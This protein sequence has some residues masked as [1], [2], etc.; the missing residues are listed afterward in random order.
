LGEFDTNQDEER[1]R[2]DVSQRPESS[3]QEEY[4]KI[5][6]S[7]FGE[8]LL[9]GMNWKPGT[10]IGMT[11]KTVAQPIEYIKRAH[12]LGLGAQPKD[13]PHKIPKYIKPGESREQKPEMELPTGP[14]G[15]KRHYKTLDEKLRPKK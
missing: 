13:M 9:R 12:R 7:A 8:A 11:N 2:Y 14:D 15:K 10:P 6:V 1:F 5:P 3:T 4:D